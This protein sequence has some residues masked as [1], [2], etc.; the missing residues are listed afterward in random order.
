VRARLKPGGF[1]L[2]TV[3]TAGGDGFEKSAKRRWHHAEA[4]LRRVAAAAGLDVAGLVACTPR[5]ETNQPVPGLAVAL[6][7]A[8]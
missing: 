7:K 5:F 1:F 4:Y 2:F 8:A 3:E 6:Q